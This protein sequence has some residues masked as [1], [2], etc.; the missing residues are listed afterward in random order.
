MAAALA[1]PARFP[2]RE[3][4][5]FL[6]FAVIFVTLVGQGLT[7]PALIRRLEVVEP[8][9]RAAVEEAETRARIAQAALDRL[10]EL[11]HE[12][13]VPEDRLQHLRQRYQRRIDHHRGLRDADAG[14]DAALVRVGRALLDAERVELERLRDQ[15]GIS[16]AV[17]RSVRRDLDVEQ[18]RL[19]R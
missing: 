9:D 4:L 10:D 13:D 7:L 2:Q 18:T 1:L 8:A 16:P 3:L 5:I 6:T 12:L 19:D 14:L 11:G 15:Q 17:F